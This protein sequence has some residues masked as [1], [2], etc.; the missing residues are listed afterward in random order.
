MDVRFRDKKMAEAAGDRNSLVKNY[1]SRRAAI[2]MRRLDDIRSAACLADLR[3]LP[4]HYHALSGDRKGQWACDLDQP[5]R[6]ILEPVEDD[7]DWKSVAV[8]DIIEITDY[9]GK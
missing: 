5:Y 4:G 1:G 6:L 2:L 9:H 3:F 7:G 8:I